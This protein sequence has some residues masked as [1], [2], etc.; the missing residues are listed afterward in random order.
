MIDRADV[1]ICSSGRRPRRRIEP[2]PGGQQRAAGRPPPR[3]RSAPGGAAKR[4]PRPSGR[5]RRPCCRRGGPTGVIETRHRPEPSDRAG[6]QTAAGSPDAVAVVGQGGT[7]G[8]VPG[9]DRGQDRAVRVAQ[10]G[11]G[12]RRDTDGAAAARSPAAVPARPS[13]WPS[14]AA[15]AGVTVAGGTACGV[16]AGRC[17]NGWPRPRSWSSRRS[18]CDRGVE[19]RR[20]RRRTR[21]GRRSP[22][23]RAPST[24]R[25]RSVIRWPSCPTAPA[26]AGR[27][28]PR[29]RTILGVR[30]D[31][32]AACRFARP[33]GRCGP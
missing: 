33:A 17:T 24:R 11:V 14:A 19:R 8:R 2:R 6:R 28:R 9:L 22:A 7:A 1:A 32:S 23:R 3:L 25:S 27:L 5:P 26:W 21:P 20:W 4:R 12:A 18:Y 16:R 31:R 10:L 15:P 30:S 13:P 29:L